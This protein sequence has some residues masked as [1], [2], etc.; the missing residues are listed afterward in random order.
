M[1]HSTWRFWCGKLLREWMGDTFLT[2]LFA[3][4]EPNREPIFQVE[5]ID[6]EDLTQ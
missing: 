1:F 2:A 3:V 4:F 6:K 5:R